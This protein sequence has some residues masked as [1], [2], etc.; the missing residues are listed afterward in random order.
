MRNLIKGLSMLALAAMLVPPASAQT[1]SG[2]RYIVQGAVLTPAQWNW[3]FQQKQDALG[4]TPVN[5]AGDVMLGRLVTT[6]STTSVAGFAVT[7]GVAPTT[8]TNG[9]MWT[10]TAGLF[11]RI[12]GATVGPLAGPA[13]GSFAATAPLTVSFPA[14]VVTYALTIDSSLVT[15]ASAL[16]INLANSNAFTVS[17]S[18]TLNA[19]ALPAAQTGTVFR[20]T[21]ATGTA[22][23]L[24]LDAYGAQAFYTA[25]CSG[26][27][28]AAPTTLTATTQCGGYNM[29]GYDGTAYGGPAATF[30][31]FA[32]QNWAVGAH[33]AYAEIA[34]TAD[35][36]TTMTTAIRFEND[37]GVTIP[38]TVSGGSKGAGTIN[39]STALYN[40]GTAPTGTGAYV[41]A[42]S[43]TVAGG[44]VTALTAFSLRDTSAAFDVTIAAVSSS[45]LTAGRTLTVDM[46]NAARTLKLGAN[47]TLAT[48]PGGITGALK[49]NGTGTFAQAAC[50]D[51]SGVAAS[52]ATDATN[53][54]NISSGTLPTGR[55]SG[56][57]TGI[58]GTGTLTAG[59]AG[60]GFTL[61]FGSATLTGQVPIANG[62][63]AQATA[64]A[65]RAASGLNIESTHSTGDAIVTI[66]ATTRNEY[67]T[68]TL[69]AQRAWT[70]P[71]ASA[72]N[73][74]QSLIVTDAFGG[75]NGSNTIL[76]TR[77]G[78]DTI[79]GTTTAAMTQAFQSVTLISDG[80]SKWSFNSA[81]VG[82]GTVTS[83]VCGTRLSGG[84]ITTTG[85][86]SVTNM[87]MIDVQVFTSSGTW[88]KP[89]GTTAVEI[90]VGGG[91]G[92]GGSA[93]AAVGN[94]GVGAGGG[95][96]GTAYK[97]ES[98][99]LGATETVTVGTGGVHG[100]SGPNNGGN[101]VASSFGTHCTGSGGTGGNS[102]G[103]ATT[104]PTFA[105]G[106]AG[107][108]VSGSGCTAYIGNAGGTGIAVSVATAA[109]AAGVG[110]NSFFGGGAAAN[111]SNN[112][113]GVN[114]TG[115][116]GGGSGG[117][118]SNS[119]T[120]RAGG[121]GM[122]GIVIVKSYQ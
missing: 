114:A 96:G 63:T 94:V 11:V 4:Y 50:S 15:T 8:P 55:I 67:T 33:G 39:L 27:T 38:P 19:S 103:A 70:L 89:S 110:G 30:R 40:N 79:N 86:C 105:S 51:L 47:L 9:D 73:P 7:P 93:D 44:S 25:L 13:A 95:G 54:S 52:C 82:G 72:V 74:G 84:T 88:T 87:T 121:D 80:I 115:Y 64:L 36:S 116:G 104:N 61:A 100:A 69:T 16:G 32:N 101:G 111:N 12:N 99:S 14:S 21:N 77:A 29:F 68:A 78:S 28:P 90:W 56:S 2:C 85:T 107:G 106:G 118:T 31:T 37:G 41:R 1:Q 92:A 97:F 102:S 18:I 113:A 98:A 24:Q 20:L 119:G 59:T 23:R 46:V 35:A 53:A 43:P 58:T 120:A 49:S 3:C 42:T 62:G 71:A 76:L 45:A 75:I 81:A 108:T 6:A 83:V 17:Q 91:G 65:A 10:T 5:K 122:S 34:V 48:D 60:A 117:S 66:A 57:Y 26:G 22:T 109:T 112:A